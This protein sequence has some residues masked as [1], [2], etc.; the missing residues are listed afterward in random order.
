MKAFYKLVFDSPI[1]TIIGNRTICKL[2]SKIVNAETCEVIARLGHSGVSVCS[3][4]DEYNEKLGLDLAL[5]RA[6]SASYENAF[7]IMNRDSDSISAIIFT[8]YMSK[9]LAREW[10]H[11]SYLLGEEEIYDGDPDIREFVLAN[12]EAR[13]PLLKEDSDLIFDESLYVGC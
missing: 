13:L 1:Y 12:V 7:N 6:K 11:Q 2:R 3:E 10:N 4:E 5:S 8:C 9:F